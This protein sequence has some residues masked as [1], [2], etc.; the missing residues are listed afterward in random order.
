MKNINWTF[1]ITILSVS[2]GWI[3]NELSQWFRIRQSDKKIKKQIL[4]N[5]LE[6]NNIFRKLDTKEFE[7][8]YTERVLIRIPENEHTEELKSVFEYIFSQLING[9]FQGN[10]AESLKEIETKYSIAVENLASID[11]ITA[12]HLSGKTK[13]LDS[14][15]LIQTGL[16]DFKKILSEDD[17]EIQN[18]IDASFHSL[19]KPDII[20]EAISDLELEILKIARSIDL[21]TWYKLKRSFKGTSERDRKEI[22]LKID[23]LL[24]KIVPKT[25]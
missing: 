17:Q 13:I 14:F 7:K 5:L 1:I 18:Q 19:V 24:D 21:F 4:F 15:N 6:T 9:L 12:Y 22:E 23:E 16:D 10:V 8:I 2:L 25:K 3:L 11:P 20:K